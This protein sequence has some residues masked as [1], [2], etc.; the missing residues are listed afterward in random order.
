MTNAY[1]ERILVRLGGQFAEMSVRV[2]KAPSSQKTI[3]C[4]HGYF[5]NSTEFEF[6][7]SYLSSHGYNVV[8]PDL[9]GRGL[10]A[11]LKHFS[12]YSLLNMLKSLGSV[13]ERYA[14]AHN[15]VLGSAYGGAI[16]LLAASGGLNL[17]GLILN[18]P[19]LAPHPDREGFT[20]LICDLCLKTNKDEAEFKRW[21]HDLYDKNLGPFPAGALNRFVDNNTGSRK[22]GFGL[23]VDES[24][25]HAVVDDMK[26]EFDL[27]PRLQA[28]KAPILLMFAG[29]SPYRQV[30]DLS[31][32]STQPNRITIV[33]DI[34]GH[35]PPLFL[36]EG[37][38]S[39]VLR[40][41]DENREI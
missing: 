8:C 12:Q 2:W 18:D 16:A 7:A 28:V 40:F 36:D 31:C 23:W 25:A 33:D 19:P 27:V 39:T 24:L 1:V 6:L 5:N 29:Q 41:L 21:L 37:I 17:S 34:I 3:F 9:L 14:T 11:R 4:I 26:M 13:I 30:A 38:C 15:F 20:Q 32:L 35:H 10:S 22:D